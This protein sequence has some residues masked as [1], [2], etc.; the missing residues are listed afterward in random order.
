[1]GAGSWQD[2]STPPDP[3]TPDDLAAEASALTSQLGITDLADAQI[4]AASR[5]GTRPECAAPENR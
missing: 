1:M 4:V 3:V 2:S 5:S